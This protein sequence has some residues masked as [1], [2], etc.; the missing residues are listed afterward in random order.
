[1]FVYICIKYSSPHSQEHQEPVNDSPH[2][3]LPNSWATLNLEDC[4]L[5]KVYFF[6]V[7]LEEAHITNQFHLY[8]AD[9]IPLA[10]TWHILLKDN[11]DMCVTFDTILDMLEHHLVTLLENI[12]LFSSTKEDLR[13][14]I[15][16]LED[17]VP[18][19]LESSMNLPNLKWK[20]VEDK[21]G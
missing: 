11:M 20:R 9:L 12:S 2:A 13:K 7:S 6:V 17:H 4:K 15:V 14:F 16:D 3:I 10:K 21:S 18:I 19:R 5:R 1:V 8:F